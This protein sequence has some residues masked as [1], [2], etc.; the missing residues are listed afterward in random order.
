MIR[1][2]YIYDNPIL[3]D[4]S[5]DVQKGSLADVKLIID[6]MFETMHRAQG[7][8]LSAIQIGIPLNIFVIEAHIESENFHLRGAYI[9]PTIVSRSDEMIKYTEGCLSIPGLAGMIERPESI[10]MEWYDDNWNLIRKEFS[11]YASR[12]VQ[13][14]Y[15]HLE[16]KMYID[17]L[18][19]LWKDLISPSLSAIKNKEIEI[20]F[21]C[22]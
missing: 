6:D 9:N 4:R 7:I 10:E 13:H 2:I 8:G 14:E 20:P 11:G 15:D 5:Y 1:P 18:D 22:K 17:H 12:I 19:T 3:R 21:L 16:G